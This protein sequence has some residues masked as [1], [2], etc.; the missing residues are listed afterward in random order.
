MDKAIATPVMN[1]G[2]TGA[3][4]LGMGRCYIIGSEEIAIFRQRDG[5]IFAMQNRCPHRQGPLAEGIVGNGKVLCPLH[6]H[7]FNLESGQGHEPAECVG[8]FPVR[9][10]N[11]EILLDLADNSL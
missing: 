9:E 1:L 11:G 5:R 3:I 7:Q 8:T 6:A 4:A 2:S 10:V